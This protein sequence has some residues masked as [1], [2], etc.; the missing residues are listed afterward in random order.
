ME[1][2]KN[3]S[4]ESRRLSKLRDKLLSRL[5]SGELIVNEIAN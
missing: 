1:E 3:N 4:L 2:V 5:M